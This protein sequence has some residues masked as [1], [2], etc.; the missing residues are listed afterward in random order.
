MLILSYIVSS[1]NN[2]ISYLR[3]VIIIIKRYHASTILIHKYI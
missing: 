1:V 2:H 3:N